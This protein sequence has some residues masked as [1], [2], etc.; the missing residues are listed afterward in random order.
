[1]AWRCRRLSR[2]L[3]SCFFLRRRSDWQ[4]RQANQR[5][6]PRARRRAATTAATQHTLPP[7][8]HTTSAAQPKLPKSNHIVL[9]PPSLLRSLA[10]SLLP[11]HQQTDFAPSRP[12]RADRNGTMPPMDNKSPTRSPALIETAG[13]PAAAPTQAPPLRRVIEVMAPK[14]CRATS[15]RCGHLIPP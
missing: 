10:S 1:M 12:S 11:S 7:T 5:R 8:Q 9:S 6:I 3:R 2:R 13:T 15:I 4:R 14:A